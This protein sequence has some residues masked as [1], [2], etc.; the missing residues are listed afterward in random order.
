MKRKTARAIFNQ[1]EHLI[2]EDIA[3]SEIL[4]DLLK[5]HIPNAIEDAFINGKIYASIF[6]INDSDHYIE[7]HKNHWVQALE[8]CLIW[9]IDEENY[10][11]CNHIKN[12]IKSIQEKSRRSPIKK[13]KDGEGF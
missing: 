11:M 10:E 7:I 12:T 1:P 2:A 5:V 8:T 13:K 6:E 4:K 3:N 9:Y